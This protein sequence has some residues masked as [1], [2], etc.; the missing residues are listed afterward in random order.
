MHVK[1]N[2]YRLFLLKNQL[3]NQSLAAMAISMVCRKKYCND[4]SSF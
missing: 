3:Y 1:V 2:K 4:P